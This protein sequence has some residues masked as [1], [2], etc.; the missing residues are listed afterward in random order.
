MKGK[1]A[2]KSFPLNEALDGKLMLVCWAHARRKFDEALKD[3]KKQATEAL[4]QI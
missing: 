4:L 3:H 2:C 1:C